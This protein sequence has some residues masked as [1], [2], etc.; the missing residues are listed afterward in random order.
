MKKQI[1]SFA[2]I[3][4]FLIQLC[5][6]VPA[7]AA[8][9]VS[10]NF[11][12]YEAGLNVSTLTS[13]S[14]S[15][16]TVA[17]DPIN[18]ESDNMILNTSG[19]N[20]EVTKS[21]EAQDGITDV[22][23]SYAWPN[24]E[25]YSHFMTLKSGSTVIARLGLLRNQEQS[26]R[27]DMA[28]LKTDSAIGAGNH[29]ISMYNNLFSYPGTNTWYNIKLRVNSNTQTLTVVV[30]TDEIT[31]EMMENPAGFSNV[32]GYAVD[33]DFINKTDSNGDDIT[34][35]D[36]ISFGHNWSSDSRTAYW[37]NIEIKP[38]SQT[39][40]YT[41][42]FRDWNGSETTQTVNENETV[43]AP[44]APSRAGYDFDG[45]FLNGAKY[46]FNAP[47]TADITLE[48]QYTKKFSVVD[49][50]FDEYAADTLIA[51]ID[52]WTVSNGNATVAVDPANE[53]N[54]AMFLNP[55]GGYTVTKAITP[56]DGTVDVA[57]KFYMQSVE[58][59]GYAAELKSGSKNIAR[60]AVVRNNNGWRND[61]GFYKS[62]ANLNYGTNDSS[63]YASALN[64]VYPGWYNVKC[65][66]DFNT[67]TARAVISKND[68]TDS[69]MESPESSETILGY[70]DYPFI[71]EASSIDK[72][73]FY[74]NRPQPHSNGGSGVYVDDIS[75]TAASVKKYSLKNVTYMKEGNDYS[76]SAIINKGEVDGS[77]VVV[78]Y[79]NNNEISYL[80]IDNDFVG[81]GV[82]AGTK[83]TYNKTFTTTLP[84]SRIDVLIWDF[85]TNYP[86][87][88]AENAVYTL[89]AT[90]TPT[91][92]PT[93][94]PTA[95]PTA[96][97]TPGPTADP[98][99]VSDVDDPPYVY[100]DIERADVPLKV[101]A[102]EVQEIPSSVSDSV[103]RTY[104]D[105][106]MK[107]FLLSFDDGPMISD[108]DILMPVFEENNLTAAFNLNLSDHPET[109]SAPM[110]I[111]PDTG[112]V[113]WI[114]N[115]TSQNFHDQ[116]VT[117]Y[118]KYE[119][120]NH[121]TN[122]HPDYMLNKTNYRNEVGKNK[123]NIETI[124]GKEC[125]S[126]VASYKD[127]QPDAEP[128]SGAWRLA[129]M[130]YI[131]IRYYRNAP[132]KNVS[133]ASQPSQLNYSVPSSFYG[134]NPTIRITE[135][136]ICSDGT[137][138]YKPDDIVQ[139][140]VDHDFGKEWTLFFG[141]GHGTDVSN[142]NWSTYKLTKN[143]NYAGFANACKIAGDNSDVLW[144]VT[145]IDYVDYVNASKLTYVTDNGNGTVSITNPSTCI[146]VWMKVGGNNIEIPAGQ[147]VTAAY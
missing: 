6:V 147:T 117:R 74:T 107:A 79:N 114:G 119:I 41:V 39:A 138:T 40:K 28:L 47:V 62:D 9:T 48:A 30:A 110:H 38:V 82:A 5:S 1:L 95:V 67:Q 137:T 87:C 130:Q 27:N 68:I 143:G 55:N 126:Y 142:L 131:G 36:S 91:P 61:F 43:S 25:K 124:F 13:W 64:G 66:L 134:W 50:S 99:D 108:V 31:E 146:N 86:L 57:Y 129:Y 89:P 44:T 136:S 96:T 72:I 145:P 7:V 132:L 113:T 4:A 59:C 103:Y 56:Q 21:F 26:W 12:G 22:S 15:G 34:S 111:D 123:Y 24:G 33:F 46:N 63:S 116:V 76:V 78:G 8:G 102:S 139:Y 10:E 98:S 88:S 122:H 90:P 29:S 65:R 127:R 11:N 32:K 18:T 35:F 85:N 45:W 140:Y 121:G 115:M 52:T 120:G 141:W 3:W 19:N 81:S 42:T 70:V 2:L 60:L 69:D 104:P 51:D 106:K 71:N 49:D 92:S 135:S 112:N 17:A 144:S 105:G 101:D 109:W 94:S 16:G 84:I 14:G 73:S 54:H 128:A 77:V 75:V 20:F 125:N 80:S 118:D 53:D 37:D 83:K 100:A 23:Y 58:S 133:W 97:P 93:P